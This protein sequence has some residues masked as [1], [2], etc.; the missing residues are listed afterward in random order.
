MERSGTGRAGFGLAS[1]DIQS[2]VALLTFCFRRAVGGL[3]KSPA[4]E[5]SGVGGA[6]P[7]LIL[8]HMAGAVGLPVTRHDHPD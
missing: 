7:F 5:G 4:D 3:L 6:L 2:G 8:L 1:V